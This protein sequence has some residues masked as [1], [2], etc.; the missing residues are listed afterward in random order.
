MKDEYGGM[1][2]RKESFEA[3]SQSVN[4]ALGGGMS[5]V[6]RMG[7]RPEKNILPFL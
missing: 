2:G 7:S 1:R 3:C 5:Y 4:S 6:V